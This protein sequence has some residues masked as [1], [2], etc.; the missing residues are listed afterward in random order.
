MQQ[1]MD[2][3]GSL[4]EGAEGILCDLDGCL[5]SG[6]QLLAGAVEFIRAYGDKL[7][8]VTNNSTDSP[9]SLS[10]RLE[11]IGLH[12]PASRI[13]L[14]G[15]CAVEMIAVQSPGAQVFIAGTDEIARHAE[16]Q[17]LAV[18]S[19]TPDIVLLTRDEKFSY[20]TLQAIIGHLLG[21]AVLWVANTDRTHPGQNGHPVPETGTLLAAIRSCLPDTVWEEVGKPSGALYQKALDLLGLA[22]EQTVAVGDNPDTDGEGARRAGIRSIIIGGDVTGA[23]SLAD[24]LPVT[25]FPVTG[26]GNIGS[27]A[28]AKADLNDD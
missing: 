23:R 2:Q 18:V 4:L 11:A 14:A 7:V 17:G 25:G 12:I 20:Q 15:I 28:P 26:D 13:L 9:V 10:R 27:E 21:G 8:V 19:D 3:P 1:D 22:P 24:L 5:I 16:A 6:N